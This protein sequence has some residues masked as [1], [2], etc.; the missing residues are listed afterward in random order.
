M[1]FQSCKTKADGHVDGGS[2]YPGHSLRT[3]GVARDWQAPPALETGGHLPSSP[4]D[5]ALD[6]AGL[7]GQPVPQNPPVEPAIPSVVS[8]QL[9][10][11]QV[12]DV[13]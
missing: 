12:C 8:S 11:W 3:Y 6:Q 9:V 2:V 10:L 1:S 5:E 13:Y 7:T 4:V